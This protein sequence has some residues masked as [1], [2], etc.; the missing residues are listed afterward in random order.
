MNISDLDYLEPLETSSPISGCGLI[1]IEGTATAFGEETYTDVDIWTK[2][3]ELPHGGSI[4]I[5]KGR[6][7]ASAVDPVDAD[8]SLSFSG[9]IVEDTLLVAK[10]RIKTLDKGTSVKVHGSLTLVGM[11]K[12]NPL[13]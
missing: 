2:S 3:R 7:R 10:G 13:G 9:L 8:A 6:G 5:G 1:A 11:T 12:P 4:S